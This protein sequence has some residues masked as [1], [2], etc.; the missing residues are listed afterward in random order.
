LLP[1]AVN[2]LAPTRSRSG[3]DADND[4]SREARV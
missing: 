4:M 2:A 3:T 1:D